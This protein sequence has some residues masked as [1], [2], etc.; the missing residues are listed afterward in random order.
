MI[1]ASKV[2]ADCVSYRHPNTMN[3]DGCEDCM[4]GEQ[5]TFP[6][7]GALFKAP[8]IACLQ[9]HTLETRLPCGRRDAG[10]PPFWS[11]RCGL[12]SLVVVAMRTSLPCGRRGG[13]FPPLWSSLVHCL[14]SAPKQQQTRNAKL[15]QPL[16]SANHTH[17]PLTSQHNK[18]LSM[19]LHYCCLH[20]AFKLLAQDKNNTPSS[21]LLQHL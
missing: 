4:H 13:G 6:F 9:R 10:F 1:T 7:L 3:V 21:L 20:S 5:Y 16:P 14:S 18:S 12:P 15:T 11:S 2:L 8:T 17:Q 19:T